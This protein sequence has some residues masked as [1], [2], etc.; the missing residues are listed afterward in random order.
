MNLAVYQADMHELMA[1]WV[2]IMQGRCS[3]EHLR[4]RSGPCAMSASSLSEKAA[5]VGSR[6]TA[7]RSSEG[8]EDYVT[9]QPL[10][11]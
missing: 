9:R 4:R 2:T 8:S 1:L 10:D 5:N 7:W 6:L 3:E 11:I